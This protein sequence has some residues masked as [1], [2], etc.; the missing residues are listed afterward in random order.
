MK[1]RLKPA[2]IFAIVHFAIIFSVCSIGFYNSIS[3]ATGGPAGPH[4]EYRAQAVEKFMNIFGP[5]LIPTSCGRNG[6]RVEW[7]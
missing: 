5:I 7:H 1:F 2:V 4:A 6:V 3:A